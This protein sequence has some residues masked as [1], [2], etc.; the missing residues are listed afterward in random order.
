MKHT[1]V[2]LN[3][4]GK[5]V[6]ICFNCLT[7]I[8]RISRNL[9]YSG[10]VDEYQHVSLKRVLDQE[11]PI[12]LF[13]DA[14]VLV[15]GYAP[16]LQDSYHAAVSYDEVMYGVEIQANILQSL[17]SQRT[18]IPLNRYLHAVIALIVLGVYFSQ[19]RRQRLSV[20]LISSTVLLGGYLYLT[21]ALAHFG[22]TISVIYEILFFVITDV[23]FII[24]KYVIERIH[25]IRYQEE[26]QEQMWSFTEAIDARTPYNA[27]HTK[28]VAEYAD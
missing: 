22:Y 24:N 3:G 12:S 17:M 25:R 8:Q 26:L 16:G 9:F 19:I 4:Q 5:R 23:Y 15:G 10:E 1:E 18:A 28:H 21:R 2:S 20:V 14:I 7:K 11:I 27:T 6:R 13:K